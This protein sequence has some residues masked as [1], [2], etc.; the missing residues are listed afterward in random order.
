LIMSRRT[1]APKR[2]DLKDYK[3]WTEEDNE[4]AMYAVDDIEEAADKKAQDVVD[5][6]NMRIY[7]L[8]KD[9]S[10]ISRGLHKWDW[11]YLEKRGIVSDDDSDYALEVRGN[12][13][14]PTHQPRLRTATHEFQE[15]STMPR[16][17]TASDREALI[18]HASELPVGDET[19]RTILAGLQQADTNED[20]E[21]LIRRASELPVGDKTRK[22]ILAGLL[23]REAGR[24]WDGVPGKAYDSPPSPGQAGCYDEG[25]FDGKGKP[26]EGKTCYRIHNEYGSGVSKNKKQYNKRYREEWME[27]NT[28]RTTCPDGSGGKKKCGPK[29]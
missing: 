22:A 15:R 14:W 6:V 18:Q 9:I 28:G 26:G 21:A 24:T 2:P 11:S 10:E 19:R 7:D 5:M 25:N 29:K 17:L 3:L 23:S 4:T 13:G 8:E 16:S 12:F 1:A 20:R 27:G